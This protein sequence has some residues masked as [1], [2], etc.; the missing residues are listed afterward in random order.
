MNKYLLEIGVEEFPSRFIASTKEQLINNVLKILSEDG[1]SVESTRIESTPRRFVLWLEGIGAENTEAFEVVRGPSARVAYDQEGQPT[2]A[3]EGFLRSKGLSSDDV[4]VESNGKEDYVFAKIT[5]EAVSPEKVLKKAIPEAIRQISNPRSMRWGGKNLRFLRPIRW[6]VSLY[7]DQVLDFDLEGIPL[8]RTTKGHRFLGHGVVEIST[9]DCYE[10][11]LKE[12]FVIVDEG[13]RRNIIVRGLNRKAREHGGLPMHDDDL[14]G[15]VVSI[16]EYPTVFIGEIPQNYLDL[17]QEVII[18][19]MKDHQRYFPVVDDG[20]K[21]LPYFLSVR[22]GNEEGIENVVAGNEKVLVP[23]LEDAKFFYDQDLSQALEDYLPKLDD[24]VFHEDLGTMLDKTGRLESLTRSLAENMDC[25]PETMAAATRA[26]RLSKADLVTQM[27]VEFTELQGV[28]GRIYAE[29][30]GEEGLVALAIEEQ[31]MPK[32]ADGQ[33]PQSTPG[34]ILS[35]ADK[36]D[37]IAGL[38]AIGVRVTGSQDPFGLRRAAN[39]IIDILYEA[40]LHI[41]LWEG[42]RDALVLY[43]EEEGLVFDYDEIMETIYNFFLG[44][45]RTKMDDLGIRYDVIDAVFASK[46]KDLLSLIN[47]GE[48]IDAYLKEEGGDLLI[49][50]FVRIESLAKKYEGQPLVEEVL[51]DEDRVL[52][53]SLNRRETVEE[54]IEKGHYKEALD[55]LKDWMPLVNDYLDKTMIMVEDE[56]LR[57]A[58]L[59]MLHTINDVISRILVPSA[60]VRE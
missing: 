5:K 51:E 50:D 40:S 16:V 6:L 26:A 42:F 46:E 2:K 3:L 12:E 55:L 15:E 34:I 59:A 19:P 13:E 27:V 58:R 24:L 18:T 28:M 21:L 48:A 36:M 38:F 33:V 52:Y 31:Y 1:L 35:L 53:Q 44:R 43:V 32:G 25:G 17:P 45:L 56:S 47:M 7:N 23:R 41:N 37:N 11:T 9:I 14:L 39:G 60:I 4:Y 10:E 8:G 54:A 30:N 20:G 57:A 29:K 22:N 49:T